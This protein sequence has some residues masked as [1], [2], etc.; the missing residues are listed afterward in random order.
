MNNSL[1]SSISSESAYHR[2]TEVISIFV[3]LCKWLKPPE[4]SKID[5]DQYKCI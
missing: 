3:L 1:G 4:M 2:V 5:L